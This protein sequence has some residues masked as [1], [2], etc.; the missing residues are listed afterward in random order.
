[1][2]LELVQEHSFGDCWAWTEKSTVPIAWSVYQPFPT[3]KARWILWRHRQE[4]TWKKNRELCPT[5]LEVCGAR[6]CS[7]HVVKKNTESRS[8]GFPANCPLPMQ[9]AVTSASH[10]LQRAQS[11]LSSSRTPVHWPESTGRKWYPSE[12]GSVWQMQQRLGSYGGKSGI[13]LPEAA[14]KH[15]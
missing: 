7:A 2:E 14:D 8:A 11:A 9:R 6:L 10:D 5:V 13:C 4:G 1:M 3:W 15:T 12:M